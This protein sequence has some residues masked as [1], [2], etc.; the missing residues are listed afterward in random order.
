MW[1]FQECIYLIDKYCPG[2]LR[3]KLKKHLKSCLSLEAW[4]RWIERGQTSFRRSQCL[5]S[6][7][8]QL[9]GPRG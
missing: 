1:D 5:I 6:S 9:A 4:M 3:A 2:R 7:S 8:A